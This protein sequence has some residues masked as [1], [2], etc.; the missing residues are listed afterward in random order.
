MLAGSSQGPEER[1]G[2]VQVV[3]A[4][5]LPDGEMR[6]CEGPDCT[7]NWYGVTVD[8]LDRIYLTSVDF[9]LYNED[10]Q[11]RGVV[12]RTLPSGTM[13]SCFGEAGWLFFDVYR[14]LPLLAF[15]G[16]MMWVLTDETYKRPHLESY[17][18][19]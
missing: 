17:S 15:D 8:Y 11:Y 12:V 14:S 9:D 7:D 16:A 19:P 6:L 1:T 3:S 4:D 18:I 2:A 13:D 5:G 10:L